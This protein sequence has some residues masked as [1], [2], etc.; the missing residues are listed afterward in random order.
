MARADAM[1]D[2][3]CARTVPGLPERPLRP[4]LMDVE[5]LRPKVTCAVKLATKLSTLSWDIRARTWS[6]LRRAYPQLDS[7]PGLA[8]R[9][10]RL[11]AAEEC[12]G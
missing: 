10:Q 6:E 12:R 5:S 1:Q 11:A 7:D 9:C 3:L 2:P 8:L 4:V